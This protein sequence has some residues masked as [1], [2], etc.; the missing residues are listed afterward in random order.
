VGTD[1]VHPQWHRPA[2]P[3]PPGVMWRHAACLLVAACPSAAATIG[4]ARVGGM[5]S[6]GRSEFLFLYFL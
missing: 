3:I 5:E 1:P 4:Q 2:Y 6:E